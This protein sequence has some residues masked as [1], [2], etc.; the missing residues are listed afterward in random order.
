MAVYKRWSEI[1]RMEDPLFML[2]V[3]HLDLNTKFGATFVE[4]FPEYFSA[5]RD[6]GPVPLMVLRLRANENSASYDSGGDA[7]DLLASSQ[8]CSDFDI[9]VQG[10]HGPNYGGDKDKLPLPTELIDL[11]HLEG[12]GQLVEWCGSQFVVVENGMPEYVY[13]APANRI[14]LD[15]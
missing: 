1:C 8:A 9:P 10:F 4:R 11:V 5:E 14:A 3:S 13:L 15:R 7:S 6:N 12:T 2:A